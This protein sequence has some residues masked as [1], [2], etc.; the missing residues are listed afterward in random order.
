MVWVPMSDTKM[1][2]WELIATPCGFENP[3]AITELA[4]VVGLTLT[5]SP[6]PRSATMMS[7]ALIEPAVAIRAMASTSPSAVAKVTFL[8]IL[9]PFVFAT[10]GPVDKGA[11]DSRI[12]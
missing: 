2:P 3:L 11:F 6:L 12:G 1:L 4:P 8:C 9:C 10:R 7:P 5:R